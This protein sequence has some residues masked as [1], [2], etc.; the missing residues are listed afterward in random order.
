MAGKEVYHALYDQ[1]IYKGQYLSSE[2]M[3][4]LGIRC[5][6]LVNYYNDGTDRGTHAWKL[7]SR[8]GPCQTEGPVGWYQ[9]EGPEAGTEEE[10]PGAGVVMEVKSWQCLSTRP[11]SKF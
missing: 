7:G 10:R 11:R 2:L 3:E 8:V 6:Q 4:L 9:A 1:G 5:R